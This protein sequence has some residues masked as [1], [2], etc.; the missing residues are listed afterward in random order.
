[1]SEESTVNVNIPSVSNWN[2]ERKS[3]TSVEN[4]LGQN[5]NKFSFQFSDSHVSAVHIYIGYNNADGKINF[6]V[7]KAADDT[8]DNT[9]AVA[10]LHPDT[11]M[12]PLPEITVVSEG[13]DPHF[14]SYAEANNRVNDY[15][16]PTKR[17]SWITNSFADGNE[18]LQVFVVDAVD[19]EPG[20]TY[21]C[22][23]GL[24]SN[25]SGGHNPD[26]IIYNTGSGVTNG[27]RDLVGLAPPFK[28]KGKSKKS[29]FG[30]LE[31]V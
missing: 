2:T 17:D 28:S 27:L 23:L 4:I 20:H 29:N 7:I 6:Q 18:I 24:K 31:N 12:V 30:L 13:D 8:K 9:K 10:V 19:F 11:V 5:G 21:D 16:N 25:E 14:I 22:Y 3:K 26:L 15:I 1:M